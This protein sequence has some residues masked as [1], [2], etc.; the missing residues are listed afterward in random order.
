MLSQITASE[1]AETLRVLAGP[2]AENA[3][4][5]FGKHSFDRGDVATA[6]LWSKMI[7]LLQRAMGSAAD[8]IG[9]TAAPPVPLRMKRVLE[10]A[11]FAGVRYEDVEG[12]ALIREALMD[13]LEAEKETAI[14]NVHPL[15]ERLQPV[16]AYEAGAAEPREGARLRLA[17]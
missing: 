11:A 1:M 15:P 4:R 3:A 5:H 12:D 10:P 2:N 13:L 16:A 8:M 9:N 7:E 17:A 14:G 6:I